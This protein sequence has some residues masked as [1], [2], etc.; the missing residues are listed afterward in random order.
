MTS[1]SPWAGRRLHFVG[2]GGA[3]MSGLALVAKELG[4]EVT[5]S[6]RAESSYSERLRAAGIEPSIGHDAANVPEAAE[7][8]VSSAIP[9]TNPELARARE[10]GPGGLHRRHLLA[11]AGRLERSIAGAR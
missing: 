4:A 1:A 5:G 3:G 6:D 9:E 7:V 2:I 10:A 8:V 11:G